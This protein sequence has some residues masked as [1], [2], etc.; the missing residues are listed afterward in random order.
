[1]KIHAASFLATR[2]ETEAL[3]VGPM[4]RSSLRLVPLAALFAVACASAARPVDDFRHPSSAGIKRASFE[5]QCP[6]SELQVVDLGS[7]TV[8]VTGCGKKAVYKNI[9]GAGWVNDTARGEPEPA[10]RPSSN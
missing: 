1:M 3:I 4:H 7:W 2:A 5:M 6:E 8:G 9:A 10:P